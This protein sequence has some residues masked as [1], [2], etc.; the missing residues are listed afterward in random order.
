MD[1][2]PSGPQGGNGLQCARVRLVR[3][4]PQERPV[5]HVPGSGCRPEPPGFAS[6]FQPGPSGQTIDFLWIEGASALE[7]WYDL[8]WIWEPL[9]YR[10]WWNSGFS[11]NQRKPYKC[12]YL[13]H[14]GGFINFET[15]HFPTMIPSKNYDFYTILWPRNTHKSIKTW[16]ENQQQK[17][18]M[19]FV[20]FL[21][22]FCDPFGPPWGHFFTK[23]G[24]GTPGKTTFCPFL[25]LQGLILH[26]FLF[27]LFF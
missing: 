16:F 12:L 4:S 20:N 17:K 22:H 25:E 10:F 2:I 1:P 3:S 19:F 7:F 6:A 21:L 15:S 5:L 13:K 18:N 24:W 11:K 9:W 27:L 8:W 23:S 26:F 14:L